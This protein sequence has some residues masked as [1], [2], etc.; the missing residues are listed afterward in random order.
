MNKT[1]STLMVGLTLAAAVSMAACQR[2]EGPA[3]RAGKSIDNAA[4]TAGK[5]LE[6]AGDKIKETTEEVK[7]D[8]SR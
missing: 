7:K 2:A 3:E 4:E 8:V 1:S 5:Q 6:K